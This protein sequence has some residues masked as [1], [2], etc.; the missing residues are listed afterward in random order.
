M[1]W[2][3][4]DLE[5]MEDDGGVAE[6]DAE[7]LSCPPSNRVLPRR[8][9]TEAAFQRLLCAIS[10]TE[11]ATRSS[12]CPRRWGHSQ[13]RYN[14]HHLRHHLQQLEHRLVRPLTRPTAATCASEVRRCRHQ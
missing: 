9:A 12:S 7:H 13:L 3:W 8:L 5:V 14:P 11:T 2:H 1:G 4:G 6:S 10:T